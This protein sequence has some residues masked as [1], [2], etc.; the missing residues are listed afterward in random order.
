M[1]RFARILCAAAATLLWSAAGSQAAESGGTLIMLV[2]PEP[3]T[4]ASYISTSGPVGQVTTKIYAGLLE[5]D[6]D[7]QPPPGLAKS[8][9]IS[10]DGKT[11]TFK[12]Q[13][14]VTFHDGTPFT[15]ADVQFSIMEVLRQVHPRGANTFKELES[16]ETPDDSTAIFHLTNPAP[17]LIRG[18]SGYETPIVSKKSFEGTDFRDNPTANKPNGTGPFKF[19]EWKKGQYIRLDKNENY[20]KEGLPYLDRVVARFIP[21]AS[22]RT[23]ALEK[24][25]VQ[26][27]AFN[28]IPN[29]DAKRLKDMDG[30]SVTTEGYTMINPLTLLEVNT[31]VAPFD[32][33]E[34]RQAISYAIDRQFIIDNVF[35]GYGKPA[36]GAIVSAFDSVGLYSA[37]VRDYTVADRLDKANALLDEA[38]LKR[39]GDG[40][41]FEM[42]LDVLPYGESWQ[43]IGE[44]LKQALAELGIKV[45]IRYED[46]P[47]W[48]K[49]TYTDYAFELNLNFFYQLS[50]PVI[51]V[52]RQYLTR[53]IRKGTVFVNGA[54]YSNPE[55]DALMDSAATEADPAKRSETYAKLQKLLAEDEPVIPLV[56]MDFITVYRDELKDAVISPLGVYASFDHAWLDK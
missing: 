41:R 12:L 54:Q 38:G 29:V 48:L 36:T 3:P 21:D 7:L 22:T 40:T 6:F 53:E 1:K 15:S 17:Y 37:D 50:D 19:V 45:T 32:K 44:Y 55:A 11:I 27:A 34:V 9:D 46:V 33:K 24:G 43:R 51:G 35:F 47:T 31:T 10:E 52:H 30:I 56:E 13:E 25:E 16:I 26:F 20:W 18:L 28:A 42:T 8:W 39:D 5:Y 49:R 2:Q 23:A 14:G 4:L